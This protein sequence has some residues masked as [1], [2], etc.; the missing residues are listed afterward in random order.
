MGLNLFVRSDIPLYI[1]SKGPRVSRVKLGVSVVMK[2]FILP[3]AAV[4]MAATPVVAT[5]ADAQRSSQPVEE[6]A[7]LAGSS[8]IIAVLAAAAVIAGIIIAADDN[9]EDFPVSA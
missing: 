6:S 8:L 7:E 5:A 2:K 1:K 9:D 3:F 4:A